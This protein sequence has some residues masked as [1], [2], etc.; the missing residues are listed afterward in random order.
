VPAREGQNLIQSSWV[1]SL[2]FEEK[3]TEDDGAQ[4]LPRVISLLSNSGVF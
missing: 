3:G 4:M 2:W 1:Q